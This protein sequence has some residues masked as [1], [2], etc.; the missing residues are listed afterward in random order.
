M[1]PSCHSGDGSHGDDG[2]ISG[3][4]DD[5]QH[6]QQQHLLLSLASSSKITIH[7]TIKR[8]LPTRSNPNPP[9]Q[10]WF[11]S[12][13]EQPLH[14]VFHHLQFAPLCLQ[15]SWSCYRFYHSTVNKQH[16]LE[17]GGK[18]YFSVQVFLCQAFPP[19][20]LEML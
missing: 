9:P 16:L 15:S 12:G 5:D 6:F 8:K 1:R 11:E 13:T 19:L 20:W 3:G 14:Q 4:G 18:K 17:I 10:P 7:P 2:S